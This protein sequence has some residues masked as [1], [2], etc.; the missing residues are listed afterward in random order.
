MERDPLAEDDAT[1]RLRVET[2]F[3]AAH[4]VVDSNGKCENLHG[5]TWSVELFVLGEKTESN[6]MVIDFAVLKAALKTVTDKLDHTYLNEIKELENP[7]SENIAKYYFNQLK[8]I[9]PDKPKLEKVRV[10]ESQKSWCE[11]LG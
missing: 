7:T 10:W 11:Y 5:H 4:K 6:G 3:A 8:N 9:L 1:F 2:T